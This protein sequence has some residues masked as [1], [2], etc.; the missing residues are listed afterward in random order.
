M[1]TPDEARRVLD[2]H[3]RV[4]GPLSGFAHR[5]G[6]SSARLYWW[7]KRL[8]GERPNLTALSLVPATVVSPESSGITIRMPNGIA[9]EVAEA[10]PSVIAHLVAEL[11]RTL[12]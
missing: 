8:A 6:I 12:A 9:I 1:W 4:G 11:T 3:R 10:T 7:R 2:E 5:H